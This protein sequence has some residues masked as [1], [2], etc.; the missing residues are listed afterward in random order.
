MYII[1]EKNFESIY[2]KISRI[3]EEILDLINDEK[4]ITKELD[5]SIRTL[6]LEIEIIQM[7][8]IK[9]RLEFYDDVEPY[10]ALKQA[11]NDFEIILMLVHGDK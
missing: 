1:S 9:S 3:S 8:L 11:F 5:N 6:Y 4:K 2:N 7:V 10:P